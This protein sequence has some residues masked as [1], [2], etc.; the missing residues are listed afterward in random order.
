MRTRTRALPPPAAADERAPARPRQGWR[1]LPKIRECLRCGI[2]RIS[3]SAG[4]RL[5][6]KCRPTGEVND[7]EAA[8]LVLLP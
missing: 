1:P 5:H 3:K 4:D 8:A 6:P 7:G 2:P